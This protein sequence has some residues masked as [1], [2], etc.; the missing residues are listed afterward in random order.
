[1]KETLKVIAAVIFWPFA[2]VTGLIV[3]GV[4]HEIALIKREGLF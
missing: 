2:I 4:K 3:C 1:M